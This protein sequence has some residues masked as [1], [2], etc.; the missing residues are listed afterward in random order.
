MKI[1]SRLLATLAL[2]VLSAL[3]YA[4]TPKS[5]S[6]TSPDGTLVA[7]VTNGES[8]TWTLVK[9]G[10]TILEPSAIGM[11]LGDGSVYAA[12]RLKGR[13]VLRSVRGSSILSPVYKKAQV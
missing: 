3:S 6:V 1:A 5:Y 4:A 11:T 12:G 2:T 8:L 13:P 9:D 10:V 7:T